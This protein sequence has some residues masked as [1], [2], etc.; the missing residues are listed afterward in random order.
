MVKR[1]IICLLFL[2]LGRAIA[3]PAVGF[4]DASSVDSSP[5]ADSMKSYLKHQKKELKKVRKSQRRTE[6]NW[7]REHHTEH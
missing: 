4:A 5:H 3:V 2:L 7:R 1:V 6:K